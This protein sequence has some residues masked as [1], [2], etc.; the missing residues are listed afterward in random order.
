MRTEAEPFF[1]LTLQPELAAGS[2]PREVASER[3]PTRYPGA[4][5]VGGHASNWGAARKTPRFAM[6]AATGL[7]FRTRTIVWTGVV[8]APTTGPPRGEVPVWE[9]LGRD[10][11]DHGGNVT[12]RIAGS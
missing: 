3:K 7:M 6:A 1:F 10:G 9:T 2:L 12:D 5:K 11:N 8:V 4:G